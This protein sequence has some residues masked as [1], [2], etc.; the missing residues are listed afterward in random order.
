MESAAGFCDRAGGAV[1]AP[2]R[3]RRAEPGSGRLAA[4]CAGLRLE[5]GVRIAGLQCPVE[6]D[7]PAAA[8]L[9]FGPDDP[10]RDPVCADLLLHLGSPLARPKRATGSGAAGDQRGALCGGA[11]LSA[12]PPTRINAR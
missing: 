9:P 12:A 8:P 7:E 4:L 3:P 10:V 1:A 11:S 2:P 6:P 5:C